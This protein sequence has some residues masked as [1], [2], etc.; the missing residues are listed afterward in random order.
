MKRV[1]LFIII[2]V[3]MQA[4][5]FFDKEEVVTEKSKTEFILINATSDSV[6]VF[7][8]LGSDTNC[9]NNVNGIFG[10]ESSGLQGSFL[11]MP[12]DT[13][14]YVSPDGKAFE[15]NISFEYPPS[16]CVDSVNY[17][18]G[19]NLF[20]FNIN[21]N[22]SYIQNPQETIDISCVSG[23]NSSIVCKL[24]DSTWNAGS[25][26]PYVKTFRNSY[27]YNNVGLIGVYPF[28]C[29]VCTASKN[30]PVCSD[31]LK[32]SEPQ[33]NNTCNVQRNASLSGGSVTVIFNGLFKG[34]PCEN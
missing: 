32:P 2:V 29:D 21:N 15:G 6:D 30:P 23:V 18:S 11:L 13:I 25:T 34:E 28:R 26:V 22:F 19:I 7:L 9:V 33:K 4:C 27:L 14:V 5:F 3:I 1:F 12:N 17:P 20:E 8:T 31:K 16:N 24:S 10:I